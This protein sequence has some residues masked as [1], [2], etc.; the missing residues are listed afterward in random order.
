MSKKSWKNDMRKL[1][2]HVTE[3][4]AEFGLMSVDE[5]SARTTMLRT[6]LMRQGVQLTPSDEA[7]IA[8]FAAGECEF[9]ELAVHFQ[10]R[11]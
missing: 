6:E 9:D 4:A 10:G 5:R 11:I 1:T 7:M 3:L 8:R 2:Q